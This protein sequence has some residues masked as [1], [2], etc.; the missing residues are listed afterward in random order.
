[1]TNGLLLRIANKPDGTWARADVKGLVLFQLAIRFPCAARTEPDKLHGVR[2]C[3][4][5][6]D[7]DIVASRLR[8]RQW[9]VVRRMPGQSRSGTGRVRS[10]GRLGERKWKLGS[11]QRLPHLRAELLQAL[12]VLRTLGDVLV[13]VG[14]DRKSTRLNSSH[15]GISY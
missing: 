2:T 12:G 11:R 10:G 9:L 15:L 5:E 4:D 14:I 1:M 7:A 8:S 13:L 3:V 6:G